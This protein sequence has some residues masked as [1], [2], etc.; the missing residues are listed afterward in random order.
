MARKK[1]QTECVRIDCDKFRNAIENHGHSA[2]D[3]GLKI[4][5]S[6]G[7]FWSYTS[8]ARDLMPVRVV[9]LLDLV[10]I[11]LDEYKYTEPEHPMRIDP[12]DD[13]LPWDIEQFADKLIS[14]PSTV[15]LSGESITELC[16]AMHGIIYDAVYNA[17]DKAM[18]EVLL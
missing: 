6:Q 2:R 15:I 10:G 13:P 8:G 5:Y 7:Y 18:R 3:L 16:N 14:A 12:E 11:H 1:Q 9:T 17:V 4:G